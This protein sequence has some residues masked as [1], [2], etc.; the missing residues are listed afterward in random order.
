MIC[1]TKPPLEEKLR[2]LVVPGL[3]QRRSEKEFPF[4]FHVEEAW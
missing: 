1:F 3:L 4:I 2:R